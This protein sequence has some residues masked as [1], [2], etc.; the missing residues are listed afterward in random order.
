MKV[1]LV[2]LQMVL[3]GLAAIETLT[4]KLG[5]TV[6][7]MAFDIAG[8]PVTQPAFEVITQVIISLLANPAFV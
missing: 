6:M 3:P 1:T 2:P 7:V 8:L 5:F 4:A